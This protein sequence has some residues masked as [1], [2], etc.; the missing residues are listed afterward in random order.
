MLDLEF[1]L[2]EAFAL[3]W[4]DV[5][6]K[7]RVNRLI[8]LYAFELLATN[9][10]VTNNKKRRYTLKDKLEF[11]NDIRN[12]YKAIGR[13]DKINIKEKYNE[14]LD[15][16]TKFVQ[17][18][19]DNIGVKIRMYEIIKQTKRLYKHTLNNPDAY[20]DFIGYIKTIKENFNVI[21]EAFMT[22]IHYLDDGDPIN[23]EE[24]QKPSAVS[25]AGKLKGGNKEKT[26]NL[27]YDTDE[28]YKHK[29]LK[30]RHKCKKLERK[31]K[32][33]QLLQHK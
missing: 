26:K 5:K 3:P 13:I 14:T 1:I 18:Y 25:F 6:Y 20:D 29:Y 27:V 12:I 15:K 2:F 16:F 7:K 11:I 21:K 23:I 24:I 33:R 31:L 28:Y 8:Y 19:R 17:K 4:G 10:I 30:Y 9:E 22:R 32:K